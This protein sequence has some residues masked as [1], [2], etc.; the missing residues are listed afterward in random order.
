MQLQ[1]ISMHAALV[2]IMGI[3]SGI[4]LRDKL[5]H[6]I[7]GHRVVN[8]PLMNNFTYYGPKEM[9]SIRIKS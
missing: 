8:K 6:C 1:N 5:V 4:R 2:C 9:N 7:S 3:P